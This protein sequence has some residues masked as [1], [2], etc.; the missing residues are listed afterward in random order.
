MRMKA[1][2]CLNCWSL[3]RPWLL[4]LNDLNNILFK[5][6]SV[7]L[8]MLLCE[9]LEVVLHLEEKSSM[10]NLIFQKQCYTDRNSHTNF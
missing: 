7:E 9:S 4:D 5:S 10:K 6:A 2:D 1:L 3:F 8:K